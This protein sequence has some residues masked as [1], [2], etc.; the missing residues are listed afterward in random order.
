MCN[1]EDFYYKTNLESKQDILTIIMIKSLKHNHICMDDGQI[2]YNYYIYTFIHANIDI[3]F[4]LIK[5]MNQFL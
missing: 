3:I 5:S 4:N 2:Y 1:E